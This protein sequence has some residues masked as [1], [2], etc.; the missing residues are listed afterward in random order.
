MKAIVLCGGLPQIAAIKELQ[1]R[2]VEVILADMNPKAIAV[3]YADKFA[4]ISTLDYEGIKKLAIDEKVD[5]LISV[6]ADQMILVTSWV[7]EQ[8]GLP[9]YIDYETAKNV[10]SKEY[11]KRLFIEG[12]VPTSKYIVR[13][14]LT[15]QDITGMSYP[16]ITK[17]VDAYS[18]KGV[19]K[20]NNWEELKLAFDNAV[21]ISRTKT[22][23]VEEFVGGKE[24]TIDVYVEEGEAKV[25]C[26]GVLDKIP[27]EGK[28]VI[29]RGR[30]PSGLSSELK[31]KIR[32]AAQKIA[33]AFKLKNT[34][35]LIQLKIDDNKVRVIEFCARTGGGI[36]Y[37]L[38]P[39]I[40]GF[41]VVKAVIDLTLGMKPHVEEY[42]DDA[43]II[44][45]F[46]YCK[47]GILNH[48]EGF[49]ELLGDGIIDDYFVFKPN[50]YEFGEIKSSGDRLAYFSVSADNDE[51]LKNKHAVAA[52]RVKAFN[53]KG[54]DLIFHDYMMIQNKKYS[55]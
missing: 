21:E 31:D 13:A 7:S 18:S 25:L 50:G 16:L 33:D 24:Y 27:Q 2:G 35:M 42:V 47:P 45:E 53:S 34:P 48:V 20:V 5:M 10:S 17:P 3:P 15:E 32:E 44:N 19:R 54:E 1:R 28:F 6:C 39:Q 14:E 46:I 41:D 51:E 11:M 22:A 38:I 4:Q 40:S 8:L 26:I 9:T 49:E 23:I 36:K 55:I 12:G 29:C 37:R 43:H 52:S 30:Y